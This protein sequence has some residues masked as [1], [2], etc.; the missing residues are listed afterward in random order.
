MKV[1]FYL[2]DSIE[3]TKMSERRRATISARDIFVDEQPMENQDHLFQAKRDKD[4]IVKVEFLE[5]NELIPYGFAAEAVV[6]DI[7]NE[8][9][10][11][12]KKPDFQ[13]EPGEKFTIHRA[14]SC[15][16]VPK[17]ADIDIFCFDIKSITNDFDFH[18]HHKTRLVPIVVDQS[19]SS[20]T[21]VVHLRLNDALI[22]PQE[23]ER[24]N[25]K[26]HQ[27]V[28]I[29]KVNITSHFV[30]FEEH[31]IDQISRI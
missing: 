30:R 13:V 2:K 10:L 31:R 14:F 9:D 20:S 19:R 15:N 12:E 6:F 23:Y 29:K 18:R 28:D 26:H 8:N 22:R 16:S 21:I 1:R 5:Y 25:I 7:V 17:G 11:K 4:S 24:L 27:Q 3:S